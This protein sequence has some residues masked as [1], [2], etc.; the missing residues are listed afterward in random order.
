MISEEE[1]STLHMPNTYTIGPT[2]I[3]HKYYLSV[4]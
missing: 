1:Q 3:L 2:E 4:L